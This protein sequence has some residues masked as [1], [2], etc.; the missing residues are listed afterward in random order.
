MKD[1]DQN[2]IHDMDP[3][4][5]NFPDPDPPHS[6]KATEEVEKMPFVL[7]VTMPP[8]RTFISLEAI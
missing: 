6:I 5:K 4:P 3:D 7:S 2:Y 8:K 1:P